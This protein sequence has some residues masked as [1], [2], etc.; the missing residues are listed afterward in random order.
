MS[1]NNPLVVKQI[2]NFQFEVD[3]G[4]FQL[5]CDQPIK[6]GGDEEF[7]NP[8][9]MFIA[10]TGLCLGTYAQFFARKNGIDL[11]NFRLEIYVEFNE[12]PYYIKKFYYKIKMPGLDKKLRRKFEAFVN[13]CTLTQTLKNGPEIEKE[14]IYE[15][16]NEGSC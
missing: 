12:K 8:T 15:I 14:F 2:K 1:N 5:R 13:K 3:F 10:T 4:K 9:Q 6:N 16:E 7:P 11:S